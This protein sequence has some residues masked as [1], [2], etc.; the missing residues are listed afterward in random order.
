MIEHVTTN[1]ELYVAAVGALIG[2]AVAIAKLTPTKKDD[3][4]VGRVKDTFDS[5]TKKSE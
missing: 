1:W 2:L 5:L 4:I 3:E